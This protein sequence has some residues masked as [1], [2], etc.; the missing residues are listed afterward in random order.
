MAQDGS[1]K[2]VKIHIK[3]TL[4]VKNMTREEA[5]KIA[6]ENPDWLI[7]DL[8]DAIENGNYPV[9]NVYVQVMEPAQAEKYRWNIFDMTKVWPHSEFPLR[10][11]GRLTMNRN[12][13]LACLGVTVAWSNFCSPRTISPTS[14]RRR[15]RR[16]RWC[17]ALRRQ[18]IRVR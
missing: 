4:G 8:F 17:Q 13:C 16:P 10:Q 3:T 2:Y 11:I 12:V 6:G 5:T 7:Q 9:W 14:N 1:F 18:L 15:S